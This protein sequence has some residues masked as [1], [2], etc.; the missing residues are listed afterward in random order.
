MRWGMLASLRWVRPLHS[1]LCVLSDE[2]GS[3]GRARGSVDGII[4]WQG[5]TT[6]GHR[7]HG[8]KACINCERLSRIMRRSLK[9]AFKVVLRAGERA[10]ADLV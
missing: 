3:A 8:A 2:A 10:D 9:R 1:I 5:D 4:I 6:R 7:F